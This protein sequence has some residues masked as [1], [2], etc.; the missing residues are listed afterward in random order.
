MAM[1]HRRELAKAWRAIEQQKRWEHVK[2]SYYGDSNAAV[3][4]VNGARVYRTP[5]HVVK[6]GERE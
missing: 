3:A 1:I 5:M 6:K 4:Y 2:V